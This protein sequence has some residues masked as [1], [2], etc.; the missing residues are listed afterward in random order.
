MIKKYFYL[1]LFVFSIHSQNLKTDTIAIVEGKIIS[2][3][4]FIARYEL[5]PYQGKEQNIDKIK[6]EILYS[7]VAEKIFSNEAIYQNLGN[8]SLLKAQEM[9]LTDLFLRD[10][11]YKNMIPEINVS[12]KEF[13]ENYRKFS[14]EISVQFL[15]FYSKNDALKFK[16]EVKETNL[17]EIINKY[18]GVLLIVGDTVSVSQGVLKKEFEDEIYKLKENQL[19]KVFDNGNKGFLI[20]RVLKINISSKLEKIN[21]FERRKWIEK[22][23]RNKKEDTIA[24]NL[25]F[26][27]LKNKSA[28]SD[29]VLF[30]RLVNSVVKIIQN[31]TENKTQW[32][33]SALEYSK[34]RS[35]L[36]LYL[37]DNLIVYKNG[38]ITLKW[39]IEYLAGERIKFEEKNKDYIAITLNKYL[40]TIIQNKFLSE[41]ANE[42]NLFTDINFKKDISNWMDNYRYHFLLNKIKDTLKVSDNDFINYF[43]SFP[44]ELKTIPIT[45]KICEIYS[46]QNDE[47]IKI[48]NNLTS[49]STIESIAKKYHRKYFINGLSESVHI[50]KYPELG[51]FA[52]FKITNEIIGPIKIHSANS[53]FKFIEMNISDSTIL[54]NNLNIIANKIKNEKLNN[55]ISMLAEKQNV[56]VFENKIDKIKVT[57]LQMFTTRQIGFGGRIVAF[58][59]VSPQF[60]WSSKLNSKN[61]ILP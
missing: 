13:K 43:K 42:K 10:A 28:E 59:M 6:N 3:E 7:I 49:G 5:M 61:K 31:D 38:A 35:D 21:L 45:I 16:K 20:A 54:K 30:F 8:D 51:V 46:E 56:K 26:N 29:S 9:Y 17:N 33:F 55:Y 32:E 1:S 14:E 58:P 36:A 53:V 2:S 47:L 41:I 18:R 24:T 50:S 15:I 60:E 4:D 48:L 12:E 57:K 52:L 19:S 44:N 11:L 37:N 23:I 40:K 39:A 34:L 22:E 25:F 27:L